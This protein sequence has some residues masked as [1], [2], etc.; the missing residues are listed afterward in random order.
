MVYASL[1][2]MMIIHVILHHHI[3]M[4]QVMLQEG[5]GIA[6]WEEWRRVEIRWWMEM[7]MI[8][9]LLMCV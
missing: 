3:Q 5:Q 1:Q 2:E 7:V 6:M 9:L 8:Y 4:M